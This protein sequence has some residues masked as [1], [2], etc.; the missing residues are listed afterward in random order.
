M[1]FKKGESGNPEGKKPNK[2]FLDALNRAI[3][4]DDS[5]KLRDAAERLMYLAAEGESWAIKELAD[6]LD[7][8]AAQSIVGADGGDFKAKVTVEFV[9][10]NP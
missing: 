6:R 3:K 4:Q 5:K 2:P 7:G 9:S 10:K 1:A 8:K